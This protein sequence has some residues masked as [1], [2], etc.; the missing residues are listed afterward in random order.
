MPNGLAAVVEAE[1]MGFGPASPTVA[2]MLLAKCEP[3]I[4]FDYFL[5]QTRNFTL[6]F[7]RR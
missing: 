7:Y 3:K 5:S 2:D 1:S 4:K 6:D